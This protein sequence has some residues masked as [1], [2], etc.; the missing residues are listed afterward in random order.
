MASK[1]LITGLA[2]AALI[3]TIGL[4]NAQS[5]SDTTSPA[6]PPPRRRPPTRR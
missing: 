6:T 2:T 1:S 5:T 3:G 4:V